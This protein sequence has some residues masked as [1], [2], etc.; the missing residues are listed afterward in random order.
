MHGR[1]RP[2][3]ATKFTVQI[4]YAFT[5]LTLMLTFSLILPLAGLVV[6]TRKK[7]ALAAELLSNSLAVLG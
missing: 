3:Q 1:R 7:A 5:W 2:C 6:S 4:A